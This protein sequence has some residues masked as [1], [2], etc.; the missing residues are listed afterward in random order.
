MIFC[1]LLTSHF[2]YAQTVQSVVADKKTHDPIED[3]FVFLDNSSTGSISDKQ[4]IFSLDL[5]EYKNVTLVF[6]HLN[7]ELVSLSIKD[8]KSLKDTIFLN[9]NATVLEEV[10]VT[11]KSKPR[12]RSRWLKKFNTE[13]LGEDYD[14]EL[15]KILNPEVLLFDNQAEKLIAEANEALIIENKVLGYRIKFFLQSFELYKNS[16]LLYNGKVFFEEL[17]GTKKEQARFKRNRKK[18]FQKTS[19]HFFASLI[20]PNADKTTFEA[21]YS[22]FNNNGD[23]SNFEPTNIDS[24]TI[25]EIRENKYEITLEGILTVLNDDLK[26]QQQASQAGFSNNFSSGIS[27]FKETQNNLA[28]SYL[29]SRQQRIIV[30]Q[31]GTILNPHEVEEA[32]Y[33]ASLRIASLLPFDYEMKQQK[34]KKVQ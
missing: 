3:V 20:N 8:A 4:G 29:W 16:D 21:G 26:L 22:I 32:G 5:K 9:R 15:I 13:F 24:I 27:N 25:K 2:I 33:W 17:A 34:T 7:Y 10:L 11:Q 18:I 1:C 23:F 14:K 31:F 30:N 19:R 6:S 28:R 12:K